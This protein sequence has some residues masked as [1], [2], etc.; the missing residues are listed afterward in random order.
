MDTPDI[1]VYINGNPDEGPPD[2]TVYIDGELYE[3]PSDIE[4]QDFHALI[5]LC[6][7]YA[8]QFSLH[9]SGWPNART[10]ALQAA[11]QPY[12]LGEYRSYAQVCGF[13]KH[14]W[15]K[16]YLYRAAPETK[17]ILLRHIPSLFQHETVVETEEHKAYMEQKYAAYHRA[18]KEADE[19]FGA[20]LAQSRDISDGEFDAF[21]RE[22]YRE[23]SALWRKAFDPKDYVSIMDD[24]CFFR[25]GELFFETIT[26][27]S[28]GRYWAFSGA[29]DAEIGR[30]GRCSE[31]LERVEP[32]L[33]PLA[34]EKDLVFYDK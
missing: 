9:Q 30:I 17:D 20:F 16:C 7:A 13:G 32:P 27:E 28:I 24:P 15:E 22:V 19:K 3:G 25:N 1:N 14:F 21:N 4:N 33:P 12:C 5:D 8:D 10:G 31:I 18:Q 26:H 11:L 29:F 6:F 23:A 34:A 2:I